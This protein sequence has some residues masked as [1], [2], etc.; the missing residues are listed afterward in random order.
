MDHCSDSRCIIPAAAKLVLLLGTLFL[1]GCVTVGNPPI[2]SIAD[3]L[4]TCRALY[5]EIDAIIDREAVRDHGSSPVRGFPYLRTTRLLASLR[6]ELTE[7]AH[8]PAWIDHMA[9]LDA[10]ARA[11]ELRNL[12]A[13]I[14]DYPKDS[15]L[16][17]L[18]TCREQL[19]AADLTQSERRARLRNVAHVEDDY[20]AW[21]QVLGLYPLTAPIMSAGI[22][23][24]H[25]KTRNTFSTELASLP[26]AGRLVRWVPASATPSHVP[27]DP[28]QTAKILRRSLDPLGIP[29]PTDAALDQLFDTYAPLWEVD[30]VD[31]NDQI[32][33]LQWKNGPVIDLTRPTLYR[34]VSHT[35]L[36]DQVLLQLNYIV[37]FPARPGNDIYA[38]QLD[39]INWR[40]TLGPDGEP[41]LYDAIHN[42]GCYHEFFP[43]HRLRLRKDLP[44]FYF[45]PPM[46]PQPAPPA[47]ERQPL[48]LRIASHTHFI[49]R[50]Y[51][52]E[53]PPGLLPAAQPLAWE[54]YDVLRSLP[55]DEGYRSLF[56]AYGL[57]A[58]TERTERFLLWPMGIRSPGAMRQWGRHPT[59]FVGRRHFDDAFLIESLFERTP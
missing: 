14:A 51:Y 47:R 59:A 22:S 29:L 12:S 2:T 56:G 7:P 23:A 40:V 57:I 24:W 13:P 45:E 53:S 54:E 38:G 9:K 37:W 5:Q 25:N 35:R 16:Y 27:L 46:L 32:G 8:W 52:D 19:M 6:D 1:T 50:L 43:S 58:G 28:W 39:G 41:W 17:E 55:A 31:E 26:V 33:M 34:K 36:G 18:S 20:V 42:C 44:A 10:Q 15:L 49:Q 3:T 21:W 11:L 48:V 30:V 4:T